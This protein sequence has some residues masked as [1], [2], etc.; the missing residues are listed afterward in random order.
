MYLSSVYTISYPYSLSLGCKFRCIKFSLPRFR[1]VTSS[2]IPCVKE[3]KLCQENEKGKQIHSITEH[4][5]NG[6][7]SLAGL[8]HEEILP[9]GY[10]YGLKI[11]KGMKDRIKVNETVTQMLHKYPHSSNILKIKDCKENKMKQIKARRTCTEY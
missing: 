11:S 2:K 10:L 4:W 5:I 9:D 3:P 7:F 6:L 1:W 8:H